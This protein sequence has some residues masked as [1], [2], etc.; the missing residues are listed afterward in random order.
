MVVILGVCIGGI[1]VPNALGVL[2]LSKDR[3]HSW[4]Y[5]WGI[6]G[7]RK[8]P[9][10]FYF[11]NKDTI[12]GISENGVLAKT[13]NGGISWNNLITPITNAYGVCFK[14]KNEGYVIGANQHSIGVI[15]KTTDF[16]KTWTTFNTGI[17]TTL[18]NMV[19]VNDSI[20]LLTGSNGILLK[21]NYKTS[22]F[23]SLM[24][25]KID[26]IIFYPNPVKD[27]LHLDLSKL[28]LL[29]YLQIN[30][31]NSLGQ[32]VFSEKISTSD[33]EINLQFL[34]SGNYF[35]NFDINEEKITYKIIKE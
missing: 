15:A 8:M 22:A 31:L 24:K 1:G 27:V 3:G 13:A 4:P 14:N 23:T 12:L 25:N 26:E 21:Y 6:G 7:A 19:F 30:I 10:D 2:Y 9:T 28:S 32:T 17:S 18:L 20:A 16:G 34:H 11:L 35:V 33:S 5:V 29:D